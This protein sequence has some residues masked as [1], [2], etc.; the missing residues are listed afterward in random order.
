[1]GQTNWETT[2]MEK[3]QGLPIPHTTG[4]GRIPVTLSCES[5]VAIATGKGVSNLVN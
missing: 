5:G 1:M 4:T 3:V 2:S